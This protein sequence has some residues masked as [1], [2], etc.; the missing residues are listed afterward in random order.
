MPYRLDEATGLV[1]YDTLEKN[2]A[3]FRPK[4]IIAGASAY[5]RDF[6]YARMRKVRQSCFW[7]ISLLESSS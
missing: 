7:G 4:L 5:A 2:A 3:L 6:D 1:D